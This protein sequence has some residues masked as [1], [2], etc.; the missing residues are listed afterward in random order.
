MNIKTLTALIALNL[1]LLVAISVTT[2]VP[3]PA[4]AQ[5]RGRKADYLMVAGE[6]VGRP[7]DSLVYILDT[8]SAKMVVVLVSS[9]TKDLQV[10]DRRELGQ[11]FKL[12]T[13]R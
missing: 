4:Q 6:A 10:I 3:A 5:M 7:N 2:L 12:P 9:A 8:Q 13:G 1:A 11:D